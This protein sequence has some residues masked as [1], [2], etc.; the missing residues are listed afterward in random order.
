MARSKRTIRRVILLAMVGGLGFST[1]CTSTTSGGNGGGNGGGSDGGTGGGG[2]G[3]NDGGSG[4]GMS[5][6]PSAT[7]T[8]SVSGGSPLDIK[9]GAFQCSSGACLGLD[10]SSGQ[11]AFVAS[12]ALSG[13]ASAG[14]VCGLSAITATPSNGFATSAQAASGN[15]YVGQLNDGSYVIFYETGDVLDAVN[16]VISVN[17]QYLYPFCPAHGKITFATPGTF[18]YTPC[19]GDVTVQIWGGGGG[20]GG[21]GA[22]TTCN[23]GVDICQGCGTTGGTGGYGEQILQLQVGTSYPITV[24]GGG[25]PGAVGGTSSFGT[26][27]SQDGGT[28]GGAAGTK[29]CNQPSCSGCGCSG[30]PPGAGA[31]SGGGGCTACNGMESGGGGMPGQVIVTW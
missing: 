23:M 29:A 4:C 18:A 25:A 2:D 11:G 30:G 6:S 5:A 24:G 13:I 16:H 28:A 14:A 19:V 9:T 22:E 3:G 26:L 1:G 17:I 7:I 31:G 15:G 27:V 12:G 10:N 8:G 20:G 21:C